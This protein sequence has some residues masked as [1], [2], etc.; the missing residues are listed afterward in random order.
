MA[1]AIQ[2]VLYWKK[3]WWVHSRRPRALLALQLQSLRFPLFL[4][5]NVAVDANHGFRGLPC[6]GV[7]G[8][9]LAQVSLG[10]FPLLGV[11]VRQTTSRQRL[12][13]AGELEVWVQG[14]S[15]C[16]VL[17]H[18]RNARVRPRSEQGTQRTLS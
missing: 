13:G 16:A 3:E 12:H 5:L 9:D 6:A 18:L 10:R 15:F 14:E 7:H 1:R 8:N 4:R 17:D 11:L 2:R